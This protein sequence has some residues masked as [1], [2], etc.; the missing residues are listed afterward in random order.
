MRRRGYRQA[1]LIVA[2]PLPFV[3]YIWIALVSCV[4]QLSSG[5]FDV[6]RDGT[7]D[8]LFERKESIMSNNNEKN[9]ALAVFS[10]IGGCVLLLACLFGIST[11]AVDLLDGIGM[12]LAISVA[13]T[14]AAYDA[15]EYAGK[16]G[17]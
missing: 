15:N 5:I 1:N 11:G 16:I 13:V 7:D 9:F 10:A 6:V 3:S 4:A 12:A 14:A 17:R 8:S 2:A